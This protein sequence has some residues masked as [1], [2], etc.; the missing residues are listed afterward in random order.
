MNIIT[1]VTGVTIV[2]NIIFT[3]TSAATGG[4]HEDG[5]ISKTDP[6]SRMGTRWPG[7]YAHTLSF[8]GHTT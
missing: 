4:G 2:V 6:S 7:K 1:T 5:Q 3:R 8:W